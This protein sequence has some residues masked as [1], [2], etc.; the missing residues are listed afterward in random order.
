MELLTSS[1]KEEITVVCGVL[2]R[3]CSLNS[4]AVCVT[5]ASVVSYKTV[6]E[7][8]SDTASSSADPSPPAQTEV[9]TWAQLCLVASHRCWSWFMFNS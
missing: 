8:D 3:P 2:Q 1:C 6:N 9:S 4:A 7:G 5:A